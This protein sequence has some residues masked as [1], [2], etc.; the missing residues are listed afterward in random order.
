MDGASPTRK[1]WFIRV[2]PNEAHIRCAYERLKNQI[3]RFFLVPKLCL[4][5]H[6]C[7]ALLRGLAW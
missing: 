1:T 2:A 4:G 5:T 7:E 6:G 3:L